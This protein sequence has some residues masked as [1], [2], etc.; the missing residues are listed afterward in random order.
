M[1]RFAWLS[2]FSAAL[3]FPLISFGAIVRLKG[4]GLACPDWPL[5]YGQVTPLSDVITPAP[6]GL[7]IALEVGHRYVAGILGLFV[8]GLFIASWWMWSRSKSDRRYLKPVVFWSSVAMGIL[9]PQVVLGG[10]TVLMKLAPATVS[11]HLLFGNLLWAALLLL[12]L[13]AFNALRHITHGLPPVSFRPGPFGK[14]AMVALGFTFVQI[15]LGGWVS[16]SGASMA[17][18]AFP[19]CGEGHAEAGLSMLQM[20][21]RGVGFSLLVVFIALVVSSFRIEGIS[22]Q[23][24]TASVTLIGLV[25]FQIGLGWYNVVNAVPVPTSS[26]HTATAATIVGVMVWTV[27]NAMAAGEFSLEESG[28]QKRGYTDFSDNVSAPLGK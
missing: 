25:L 15:F 14:L 24:R 27:F 3:T 1:R 7:G 19:H 22:R 9:A 10:L 8:L 16:A 5:C 11:L 6:A 12:T 26:L 28:H 18:T 13:S 21:H 23:L 17:C 2:A 20:V 4:A